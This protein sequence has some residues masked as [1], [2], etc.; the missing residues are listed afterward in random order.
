MK[1]FEFSTFSI[2]KNVFKNTHFEFVDVDFVEGSLPC[3]LCCR[4]LCTLFSLAGFI[5]LGFPDKVFNEADEFLA[6][7]CLGFGLVPPSVFV[8]F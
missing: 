6:C 4:L 1:L 2:C 5:Y 3:C 7:F 8:Y